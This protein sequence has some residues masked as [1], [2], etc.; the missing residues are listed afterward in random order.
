MKHLNEAKPSIKKVEAQKFKYS[1]EDFPVKERQEW[2][3]EVIGR[4][5]ANV[6]IKTRSTIELWRKII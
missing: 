2:L 6:E 3:R 1:T 4:E 5:Y